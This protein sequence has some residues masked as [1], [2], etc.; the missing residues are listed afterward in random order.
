MNYN[1]HSETRQF[2]FFQIK[3][4]NCWSPAYQM[5]KVSMYFLVTHCLKQTQLRC[6]VREMYVLI[7]G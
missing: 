1:M 6:F 4:N 2:K 5:N 3:I 7:F